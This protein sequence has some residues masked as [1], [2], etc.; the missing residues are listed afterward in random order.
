MSVVIEQRPSPSLSDVAEQLRG[1][2]LLTRQAID[3]SATVV[4]IVQAPDLLGQGSVEDA[5]VA[6]GLVGLMRAVTFEGASKGWQINMVAVD[7]GAS[8]P[9]E[10]IVLAGELGPLKGQILNVGTGHMGKVIP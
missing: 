6:T 10:L 9:A 2:F 5:A 4:I 8:A 1:A 3:A 7:R